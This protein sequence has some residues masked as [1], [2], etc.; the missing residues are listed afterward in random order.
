MSDTR[1]DK[2]AP[3]SLKVRF[4][5]ATVD[6]FIEQY[7]LDISRGGLFIK[8]KTPMSIG[9]LLK[10]E[11]QLKDESRLIHGVGRVVW[12]RDEAE[13]A[14]QAPGMGIKFIKMDPESRTLVEKM[15]AARGDAPGHFEEGEGGAAAKP[16]AGGGG[17]FPSTSSEADLPPPEDR[18]Q[19]RHASEFL[20]SAL[21][22]G[23]AE[24]A[25]KEAEKKAEEAR[26]RTEE[27]ERER[28]EEAAKRRPRIKKTMLGV[29]SVGAGDEEAAPADAAVSES[30]E[31]KAITRADL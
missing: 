4:K 18:T 17:F 23:S 28:A 30:A 25:R 21:A 13:A 24:S 31:T 8:S 16:A 14:G 11:F 3:I 10:F 22:E 7:S 9:T 5:S 1:K 15:V 2:R 20:A 26:K 12:K 19:V 29:G 6:E 27:I